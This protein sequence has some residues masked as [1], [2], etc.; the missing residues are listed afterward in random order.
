MN[1]EIKCGLWKKKSQRGTEY[2]SGKIKI[3][4]EG[5]YWVNE[6]INDKKGNDKAPDFQLTMKPVEQQSEQK[7]EKS[8]AKQFDPFQEFGSEVEIKNEDL[9]F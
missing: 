3:D 9:P 8:E 7:E 2:Y 4:K 1:N 6:F 5:E